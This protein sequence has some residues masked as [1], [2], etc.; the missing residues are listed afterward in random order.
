VGIDPTIG[1]ST[2]VAIQVGPFLAERSH[3]SAACL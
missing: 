3:V 2:W 1:G